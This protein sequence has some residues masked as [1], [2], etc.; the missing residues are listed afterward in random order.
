MADKD[1]GW[2]LNTLKV[3]MDERDR[4]YGEVSAAKEE[5][6]KVALSN[7]EKANLL[8]EE[9]SQRWRD[10]ANEWR[11]AMNDREANFLHKNMGLVIGMLSVVSL[12]LAVFEKFFR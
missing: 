11:K 7:A 3:L 5:A 2:T 12:L 4:R 1:Q 9:N 10:S 8:A 6:V